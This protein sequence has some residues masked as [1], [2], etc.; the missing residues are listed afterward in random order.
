[1][2]K[3]LIW[4]GVG[5]AIGAS[6]S[7]LANRRVREIVERYAPE[8]VRHRVQDRVRTAGGHVGT[9]LSDGRVAMREREAQLKGRV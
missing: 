2:I 7:Y 3:R 4:L 6:G 9:A 5:A 1:M 8:E